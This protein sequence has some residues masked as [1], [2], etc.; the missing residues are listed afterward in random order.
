MSSDEVGATG[1]DVTEEELEI[2]R[3]VLDERVDAVE[4]LFN[5]PEEPRPPKKRRW[6]LKLRTTSHKRYRELDE[7]EEE[8]TRTLF[9]ELS[10]PREVVVAS[11]LVERG[12][13]TADPLV[14]ANR[15]YVQITRGGTKAVLRNVPSLRTGRFIRQRA[16]VLFWTAAAALV[17][18][19]VSFCVARITGQ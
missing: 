1:Q 9:C 16:T 13:L 5:L 2:L 3:R 4:L 18:A 8:M 7:E 11:G 17:T 15:L 6:S 19:L 12:Y 10:D 14:L